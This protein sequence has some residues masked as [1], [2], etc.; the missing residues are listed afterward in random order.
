MLDYSPLI[1]Y[2]G[3]AGKELQV[4][5]IFFS[6]PN[7]YQETDYLNVYRKLRL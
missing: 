5:R 7:F 3:L 6:F 2:K 1:S 4:I